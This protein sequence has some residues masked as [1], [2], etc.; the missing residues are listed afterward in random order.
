VSDSAFLLSFVLADLAAALVVG[1]VALLS[2]WLGWRTRARVE[3]L[4]APLVARQARRDEAE[5]WK[6]TLRVLE[7]EIDARDGIIH[8]LR[9]DSLAYRLGCEDGASGRRQE[10]YPP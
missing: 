10:G 2:G 1:T 7:E 3:A 8:D 4:H 9:E 5:L 6:Q